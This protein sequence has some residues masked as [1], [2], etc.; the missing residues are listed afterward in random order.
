MRPGNGG[1]SNWDS[2]IRCFLPNSDPKVTATIEHGGNST[3]AAA[4]KTIASEAPQIEEV[5]AK[6]SGKIS[7]KI[8]EKASSVGTLQKIAQDLSAKGVF[9]KV[10]NPGRVTTIVATVAA[11]AAVMTSVESAAELMRQ[12]DSVTQAAINAGKEVAAKVKD[13]GPEFM[14][15]L[16]DHME[17]DRH[18]DDTLKVAYGEPDKPRSLFSR[19]WGK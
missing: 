3:A 14:E 8:S 4:A 7:G 13:E 1:L 11:T 6:A 17:R 5:A 18:S 19:L 10:K 15:K 16:G 2:Q 12:P 9:T